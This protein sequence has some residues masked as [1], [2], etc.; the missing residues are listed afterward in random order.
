MYLILLYPDGRRFE[1]MVLTA[2]PERLR[3]ALKDGDDALELRRVEGRWFS[4]HNE[5]IQFESWMAIEPGAETEDCFAASFESGRC[6]GAP[7][8]ASLN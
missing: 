6:I 7:G 1:A 5:E 3:V 8:Y 4:E 2:S